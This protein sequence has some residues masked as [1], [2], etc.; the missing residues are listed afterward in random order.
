MQAN[1]PERGV[2]ATFAISRVNPNIPPDFC[3]CGIEKNE[4]VREAKKEMVSGFCGM[5]TME[6][7]SL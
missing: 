2:V 7:S 5:T 6:N 1:C 3:Y 4:I